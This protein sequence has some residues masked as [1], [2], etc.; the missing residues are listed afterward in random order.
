MIDRTH[1]GIGV[2]CF[3]VVLCHGLPFS[4][5]GKSIVNTKRDIRNVQDRGR[6]ERT[7]YKDSFELLVELLLGIKRLHFPEIVCKILIHT[8]AEHR[9][10]IAV[11]IHDGIHFLGCY[12]DTP[13]R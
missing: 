1:F 7:L 11:I 5:V 6:T 9:N 12:H 8:H 10:I 3:E 2:E 13:I 4:L